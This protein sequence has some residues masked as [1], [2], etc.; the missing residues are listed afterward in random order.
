MALPAWSQA[1]TAPE[2]PPPS[3]P[4][5]LQVTGSLDVETRRRAITPKLVLG[6]E[7]IERYGDFNVLDVLKRLPSVV[8]PA[9]NSGTGGPRLRGLSSGFTTVLIDERVV[10]EGF[11][12][13]TL[14]TDQV[15]RIE[16]LRAP[17][18]STGTSGIAG[19]IN[20]VLR[21]AIDAEVND[22]RALVESSR[23]GISPRV[24][25]SGN[26]RFGNWTTNASLSAFRRALETEEFSTLKRSRAAT[27]AV[28]VDDRGTLTGQ[29]RQTGLNLSTRTVWRGANGQRFE[30]RP[31]IGVTKADLTQIGRTLP[32]EEDDPSRLTAGRSERNSRDRNWRFESLYSHPWGAARVQ[33]R[34]TLGEVKS[35][36]ALDR[37][38]LPADPT[39]DPSTSSEFAEYRDRV[40]QVSA[41]TSLSTDG[42][43]GLDTGVD[44]QRSRRS[45]TGITTVGDRV[46]NTRYDGDLRATIDRVSLFAQDEWELTPSWAAQIGVRADHVKTEAERERSKTDRSAST[47]V[48]PLAHLRWR[49]PTGEEQLLPS[50]LRL[51]LTRSYNAPSTSQLLSNPVINRYFRPGTRNTELNLDFASN[52]TLRPEKSWG[53]DLAYER[54]LNEGGVL[55][56]SLFHRRIDDLI[57]NTVALESVPWAPQIGRY[58]SRPRNIGKGTASGLELDAR[59]RVSELIEGGPDTSVRASVS[60]LR[61]RVKSVPGPDNRLVEQP[62]GT[63]Y[64]GFNQ[65]V[66]GT[67]MSFGASVSHTP[68]YRLQ[69]QTRR[70]IAQTSTTVVDAYALYVINS[71]A[72]LRLSVANALQRDRVR[73]SDITTAPV[74]GGNVNTVQP[75]GAAERQVR[76]AQQRSDAVIGLRLELRL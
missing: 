61:S 58:V 1:P 26:S 8:L 9:A 19:T 20:I 74:T 46:F 6:R 41:K 45:G 23:A 48:S 66:A 54:Y 12:L 27:G 2:L 53:L 25:W 55:G 42:G 62:K 70:S 57:R 31:S 24:S 43:H 29:G 16:I 18:A 60:V 35:R 71:N 4:Q 65:R 51:S 39:V 33:W 36:I 22:W 44:L 56:A 32:D 59:V 30:L 73:T 63:G 69:L 68:G 28:V 50:Q 72:Q 14:S 3:V 17:S 34:A 5:Q 38:G 40:A 7:E 76:T 37:V 64:L 11:N 52:P 21:E 67:P 10:P 47:I 75:T 15:E 49:L 13:E